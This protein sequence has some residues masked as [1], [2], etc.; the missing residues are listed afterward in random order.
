MPRSDNDKIKKRN[1][2][3]DSIQHQNPLQ[4]S[5]VTPVVQPIQTGERCG[6]HEPDLVTSVNPTRDP[7]RRGMISSDP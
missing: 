2:D 6:Q 3:E 4:F 1:S 5:T 7:G